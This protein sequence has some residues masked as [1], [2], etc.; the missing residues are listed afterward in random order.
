[1]SFTHTVPKVQLFHEKIGLNRFRSVRTLF[2]LQRVLV[3]CGYSFVLD[4]VY[5]SNFSLFC[6]LIGIP[7]KIILCEFHK[8][9]LVITGKGDSSVPLGMTKD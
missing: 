8:F 3:S 4:T 2:S 9:F 5:K 6:H 7:F 1:M